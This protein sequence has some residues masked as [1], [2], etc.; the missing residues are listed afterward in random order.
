MSASLTNVGAI[1]LFVDDIARS[2]R[3]YDATFD[4]KLVYEDA[5]AAA[6]D[7]G[8]TI[9]NLLE[10]PAA[11]ELI[12]PA[13][14]AA[15][16]LGSQLQLT[17]WVEDTDAACAE[18]RERGVALVNGPLDREWGMRTACFSD[19]DGHIWEVAQNLSQTGG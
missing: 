17:I 3:F 16:G 12:E 2:K 11:R 4:G 9:V 10:R 13:S 7:F 14:V 18:L 15:A 8:N 1:T 5:Q 6:F 19:P